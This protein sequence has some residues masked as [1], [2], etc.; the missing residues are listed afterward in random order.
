MEKERARRIV[1]DEAKT[2]ENEEWDIFPQVENEKN[3]LN[4]RLD[5]LV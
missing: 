5:F 3:F 2:F 1:V 4:L